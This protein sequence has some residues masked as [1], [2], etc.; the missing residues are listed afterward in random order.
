[1]IKIIKIICI[2]LSFLSLIFSPSLGADESTYVNQ[3]SSYL[4]SKESLNKHPDQKLFNKS[5]SATSKL[6]G[7]ITESFMN[8]FFTASGKNVSWE[9][10]KVGQANT[11]IDGLFI[12]RNKTGI[13]TDVMIVESKYGTS[14][15]GQTNHGQQTSHKWNMRKL[16]ELRARVE[17]LKG[18]PEYESAMKDIKQIEEYLSSN[19]HAYRRRLFHANVHS[20]K[21]TISIDVIEGNGKD[22]IKI[23]KLNSQ[24]I[25]IDLSNRPTKAF[26]RKVYDEYF[27]AVEEDLYQS[28][29]NKEFAKNAVKELQVEFKNKKINRVDLN[30]WLINKKYIAA[31]QRVNFIKKQF[32]K[33]K[34][35]YALLMENVP[36]KLRAPTN[37]SIIAGIFS[38]I[39][40]GWQVYRGE[41]SLSE[42]AHY[43]AKDSAL[44]GTAMY[45]SEAVITQ[46]NGKLA[47]TC[48]K[49]G[50]SGIGIATFIFDETHHV[51]NLLEGEISTD[52]F[53]DETSNALIKAT[54]SGLASYCTVI[55]TTASMGGPVVMAVSIGSYLVVD[56][57]IQH[58][59]ELAQKHLFFINDVVGELPLS[60]RNRQS[61]LD[62]ATSNRKTI[63]DSNTIERE[64]ILNQESKGKNIFVPE[65]RT[66][67]Q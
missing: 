58:F 33:A 11:G 67:V 4:Y 63:L 18:T 64:S 2:I 32:L 14:Q 37:A 47:L 27:K 15:L 20:S 35:S 55:W 54:A 21:L 34:R 45:V 41:E 23:N 31:E 13:I 51:Y 8:R 3:G 7:D 1:M 36:S 26:P 46:V 24:T 6:N 28:S 61:I 16:E 43:V 10:F 40:H 52:E 65:R 30:K 66:I 12:K 17:K 59:D 29:G 53:I 19:E 49:A 5:V 22:S 44:A 56:K 57:A 42:A 50:S 25:E 38:S 60:L 62:A 9:Q 39:G 48:L